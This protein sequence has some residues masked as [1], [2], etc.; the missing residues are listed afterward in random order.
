MHGLSRQGRD[1]DTLARALEADYRVVCPDIAGR[2]KSDWLV[3]PM[4]YQVPTYLADVVT[5]L[6][7]L[8]A[9]ELHY[10]G[11]SMGG[12]IGMALAA[13]N[14]SPVRRLVLNDVGPAIEPAAIARIAGYV[15]K[16][17]H[18]AS[19]DEAAD[20]LFAISESFGP[21]TREQWRALTEPM[22]V[23][24]GEGFKL[25]YDPAIAV[26]FKAATPPMLAAGEALLWAA[27]DRI[28]A[29]TLLL[30][31]AQSDLLS[32]ATAKAMAGRGPKARLHEFEGVGHAPTFVAPD[33]VEVVRA[34]LLGP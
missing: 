25:H 27:Y 14:G 24:D 8:D 12:L 22:L 34:F 21:H 10:L 32:P 31:G 7:R 20:H 17:N 11:T 18:W 26:A 33:Q 15:G 23:P 4:A 19:V 13:L 28:T 9:G 1:F 29:P 30:R 3:D 6:A 16:P 5:L 2:G